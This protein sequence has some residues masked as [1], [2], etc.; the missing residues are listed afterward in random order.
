MRIKIIFL[1][2]AVNILHGD[3][4]VKSNG[5]RNLVFIDEI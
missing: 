2:H 5:T 3:R 1:V 4:K